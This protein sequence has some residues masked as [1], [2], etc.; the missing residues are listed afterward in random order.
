MGK[1]K[2]WKGGVGGRECERES[3]PLFPRW[4]FRSALVRL[5]G[6][7]QRR[8][9][10]LPRLAGLRAAQ[11]AGPSAP[12]L[13]TA[14]H[15]PLRA[16]RGAGPAPREVPRSVRGCAALL[17]AQLHCLLTESAVRRNYPHFFSP[18]SLSLLC[19]NDSLGTWSTQ[20]CKTVLTDASHTKCLCDRLST[21]AILAQQPREIVSNEG[22]KKSP[23]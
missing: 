1:K 6:G 2:K 15:L 20:G 17:A 22:G 7:W 5:G 9:R 19:R 10:L 13:R 12:R 8:G 3:L 11:R 4:V 21:F 16:R 23:F 14:P 18:F